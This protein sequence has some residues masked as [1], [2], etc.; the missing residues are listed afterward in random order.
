M[1][2]EN[3]SS[4]KRKSTTDEL[5]RIGELMLQLPEHYCVMVESVD[6]YVVRN[7]GRANGRKYIGSTLL[8]ALE[9]ML[10]KDLEEEE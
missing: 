9:T 2:S 7:M 10:S 5:V 8:I 4:I 1:A 3:E 6:R